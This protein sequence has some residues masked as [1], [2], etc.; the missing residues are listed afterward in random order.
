MEDGAKS[1]RLISYSEIN[2]SFVYVYQIRSYLK[3]YFI[4]LKSKKK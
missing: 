3:Q 1:I 4:N 2:Q